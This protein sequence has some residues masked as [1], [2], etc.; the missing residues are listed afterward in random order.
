[1][2]WQPK[3]MAVFASSDLGLAGC[4]GGTAA[5]GAAAGER[6]AAGAEA[7]GACARARLVAQATDRAK[8]VFNNLFILRA[9]SDGGQFLSINRRLYRGL[10]AAYFVNL[11]FPDS[12]EVP[13]LPELRCHA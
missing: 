1:M 10:P 2:L 3:H 9:Q 8:S 12:D 4:A 6:A 7:A 5:A 11:S 13:R